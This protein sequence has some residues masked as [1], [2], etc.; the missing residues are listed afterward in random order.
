VPP[1]LARFAG[2]HGSWTA[3]G[4]ALDD[5]L[6]SLADKVWKGKR[7]PDL[8]DLVIARLAAACGIER[9]AAFAGLDDILDV[10]ATGADERLAYQSR[11]P[12]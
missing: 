4:T 6:V 8:E 12:V 10:I 11:H 3:P 2:T 1:R 7:V 9:W 5:H